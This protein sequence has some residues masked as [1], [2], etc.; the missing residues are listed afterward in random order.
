MAFFR[1]RLEVGA[2]EIDVARQAIDRNRYMDARFERGR[3]HFQRGAEP[4]A[5]KSGRETRRLNSANPVSGTILDGAL[6]PVSAKWA[7]FLPG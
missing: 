1:E 7:T 6:N 4:R 3:D 2:P 5:F